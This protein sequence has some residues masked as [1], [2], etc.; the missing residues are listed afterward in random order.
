MV[1]S[2]IGNDEILSKSCSRFES[3]LKVKGR[4]IVVRELLGIHGFQRS[5]QFAGFLHLQSRIG[6]E[7]PPK[8]I[9]LVL[10]RVDVNG[11]KPNEHFFPKGP[12]T[13]RGPTLH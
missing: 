11:S 13:D 2:I 5:F 3:S 9:G 1:F 7:E 12:S 6:I 4:F 10:D 8:K